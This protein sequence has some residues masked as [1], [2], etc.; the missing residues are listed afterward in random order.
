MGPDRALQVL[1]SKNQ[2]TLSNGTGQLLVAALPTAALTALGLPITSSSHHC[3]IYCT[4]LVY[5][6]IVLSGLYRTKVM[7]YL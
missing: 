5:F 3:H 7:Y 2:P 4:H 6:C 1:L